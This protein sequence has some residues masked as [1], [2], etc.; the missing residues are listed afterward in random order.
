MPAAFAVN[1]MLRE[2]RAGT[3]EPG[4]EKPEADDWPAVD[5]PG[6]PSEFAGADA[7]AYQTTFPDPRGDEGEHALLVLEGVYAHARVWLNDAF[8]GE[9][10]AYF[11]PCR[12]RLDADLQAENELIVECRRPDDRFGGSYES[13]RVPDAESVPGIWWNADIETYGDSRIL[14]LSAR[15]RVDEEGARFE[16]RTTVLAETALEDSVTFSVKPEGSRRGRGMMQRTGVT[17]APGER[18]TVEHTIEIRDP[19]LW[20]PHELGDQSR[21][22]LRAK[23]DDERTVTTGLCSVEYDEE[24]G[25]KVNGVPVSA[26]G[27]N[28]LA[29][30]PAD[31]QR[32]VD[33]NATVVRAQA[34][35]PSPAVYEAADDAGVLVWQDLPLTGPGPFD[36]ERGRDLARGLVAANDHHPSL[37]ALG[38]HDDPVS[39]AEDG[40]GSGIV[41][42]LRLRWRLWR[43]EYDREAAD[44]VAS[45]VPDWLVTIPVIGQPGIDADATALF[46]GWEYGTAA[47]I[48]RLLDRYPAIG[49]V[50]A[51]YGAGSLGSAESAKDVPGFDHE[52]HDQRVDGDRDASHTYQR[53]VLKT[54]TESLRLHDAD[55][56]IASGLRDLAGAGMGV[57]TDE[58]EPKAGYDT[59]ETA[60]EPVQAIV[61]APTAGTETE[62][63]VRNDL[64]EDVSGRVAW[65][66]GDV[67][68]EEEFAVEG[69]EMTVVE[70][71]TVPADAARI[72][73][74]LATPERSVSNTYHL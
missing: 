17:A 35:V 21:Y 40:L 32:A 36:V 39:L 57:I 68:G 2:W 3:V 50:V 25:L 46:P 55:L 41:D 11:E 24:A 73:T 1:S 33:L 58:G 5:V 51:D 8:L 14:D 60:F 38:V 69:N 16:V 31:V 65:E 37:A 23:L 7:V 52:R 53:D 4:G 18:T 12:L 74:S 70:S 26:R 44:A 9:H 29:A 64:P 56:L 43:A 45:A 59:L 6:K 62:L 66:T 67:S 19:A 72:E 28:L 20:W 13:D 27:I 42:R 63:V 61:D 47:D 10:D 49:D 71:I 34:H 48:D 30:D 22:V 54:V 15:P